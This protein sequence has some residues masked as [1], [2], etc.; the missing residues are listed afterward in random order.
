MT[1]MNLKA[2]QMKRFNS[3]Q[4]YQRPVHCIKQE[5]IFKP[6]SSSIN[7]DYILSPYICSNKNSK[8]SSGRTELNLSTSSQISYNH[9]SKYG[10]MNS[11]GKKPILAS[12]KIYLE[13]PTRQVH[14]MYRFSKRIITK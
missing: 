10:H 6:K 14:K 2:K 8:S 4:K 9:K 1:L 12:A 13:N 5:N 11:H 3:P 7:L